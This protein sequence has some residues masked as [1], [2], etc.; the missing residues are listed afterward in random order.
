MLRDVSPEWIGANLL[1]AAAPLRTA[2]RRCEGGPRATRSGGR[3][4]GEEPP[5]ARDDDRNGAGGSPPRRRDVPD[6]L[7]GP[8]LVRAPRGTARRADRE[9]GPED[10]RGA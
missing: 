6:W 4:Q 7:H 8:R 3:G 5:E 10:R 1:P 2:R 9:G